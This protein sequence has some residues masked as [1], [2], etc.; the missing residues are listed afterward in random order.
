M[1]N[2]GGYFSRTLNS[3]QIGIVEEK[4][5]AG[6]EVLARKDEPFM[7]SVVAQTVV[8]LLCISKADLTNAT[9]ISKDIQEQLREKAQRK[10]EWA[11]RRFVEICLGVEGVARWDNVQEQFRERVQDVARR[12]PK[13]NYQALVSFLN[14]LP[15]AKKTLPEVVAEMQR[16]SEDEEKGEQTQ[17]IES[18][19]K[20]DFD[21]VQS[22]MQNESIKHSRSHFGSPLTATNLKAASAIKTITLTPGDYGRPKT[23][24]SVQLS[25]SYYGGFFKT[26]ANFA[27]QIGDQNSKN[28]PARESIASFDVAMS[29][30]QRP[31][32]QGNLT[33]VDLIQQRSFQARPV[34]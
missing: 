17:R 18:A 11:T 16:H 8:E 28:Q 25:D 2:T 22:L 33:H 4:Q 3:F 34:T 6:D 10:L 31:Q 32:S 13:A 24:A 15:E 7:Y 1:V 12:F 26:Q 27:K 23:A 21:A 9:K 14:L 5:W 29:T 30:A 19:K 20:I